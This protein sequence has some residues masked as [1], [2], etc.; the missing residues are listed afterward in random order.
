[1]IA[2]DLIEKYRSIETEKVQTELISMFAFS[3]NENN[4]IADNNLAFRTEVVEE[5]LHDFSE[6]DLK[7][8]R[9]IF[10][11]ELKCELSTRRHDNLYQLCYYLFEIGELQDV[12]LIYNAK[13]NSKNMDVGT[14]LDREMMYLN[15]P[16][17]DVLEFVKS[18][19]HEKPELIEKN[20]TILTELNNLK[21]QPK[22]DL[23]EYK[24]FIKGYFFGHENQIDTKLKKSWW[25]FWK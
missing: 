14:M 11:Q 2:L 20:K 1:M 7:L 9:E 24:K 22:N 12:F 3:K 13:F 6:K 15:R 8:I 23:N 16:I 25:E 19:L 4:E 17:D 21:K 10:N 5:L 18:E